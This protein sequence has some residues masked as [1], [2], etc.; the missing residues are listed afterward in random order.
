V[1]VLAPRAAT[2]D[3]TSTALALLPVGEVSDVLRR[4]GARA[5]H[6]LGPEGVSLIHA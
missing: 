6:I 2:A 3:A 4:L 1:S 5:A